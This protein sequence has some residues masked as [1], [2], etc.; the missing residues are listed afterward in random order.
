MKT[1]SLLSQAILLCSLGLVFNTSIMA[2][3]ITSQDKNPKVT[4]SD[5]EAKAAKAVEAARD[6]NAKFVAAEVF[7]KKYGASKARPQVAQYLASQVFEVTDAT[8]RLTLAQKYVALF[9]DPTEAKL[10]KPALIDAYVQLNR[11]DEAFDSGASYLASDPE[12]IQVRVLLA[13]AGAELA[14]GQNLKHA[15]ATREYGVQA[16]ELLEADKKSAT[17]DNDSWLKEKAMLPTLY[18]RMGVMSLIEQKPTEAQVNLEKAAKLNPA[19]PLNYALL[20]GITNSEY[21][22]VAQTVR[23]LPDGKSKDEMLQKANTLI[24]KVIEQYA[25]AVALSTGKPQYQPLRDQVMQDLTTYYKYRHNNS[26]DGLQKYID[27]Y[28]LP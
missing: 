26:D 5:A 21:Q 11:F 3:V 15:K 14:R 27:G 18:Q 6:I 7:V 22:S 8:Q 24:D 16:I 12:D 23:G 25:R 9:T 4:V 17:M 20:G 28:K 19:D 13:M 1:R 2:G 10:V